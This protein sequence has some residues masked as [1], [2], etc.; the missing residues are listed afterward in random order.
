MNGIV[1]KNKKLHLKTEQ[2]FDVV[3]TAT[4]KFYL[5][6]QG[7]FLKFFSVSN[8]NYIF[9]QSHQILSIRPYLI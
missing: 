8:L 9:I 6:I 3:R 1:G 7:E 5:N 2:F 4:K